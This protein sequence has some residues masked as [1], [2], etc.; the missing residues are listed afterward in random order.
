LVRSFAVPGSNSGGQ[1]CCKGV[2]QTRAQMDGC[3][4]KPPT[5]TATGYPI[6]PASQLWTWLDSQPVSGL[7]AEAS[8]LTFFPQAPEPLC[9]LTPFQNSLSKAPP[10]SFYLL[11]VPSVS[12]IKPLSDSHLLSQSAPLRDRLIPHCPCMSLFNLTGLPGSTITLQKC[13]VSPCLLTPDSLGHPQAPS[14]SLLLIPLPT[15]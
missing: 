4:A 2:I 15:V 3:W 8:G 9:D 1:Q 14:E 11:K 7:T 10:I 6:P 12:Q 5:H 13:S